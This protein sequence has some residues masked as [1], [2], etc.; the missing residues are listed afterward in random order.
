MQQN[1]SYSFVTYHYRQLHWLLLV[2]TDHIEDSIILTLCTQFVLLII[3]LNKEPVGFGSTRDYKIIMLILEEKKASEG[4]SSVEIGRLTKKMERDR[5][6][7][8]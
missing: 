3:V 4:N 6:R 7:V 2:G 1:Y 5:D 8:E